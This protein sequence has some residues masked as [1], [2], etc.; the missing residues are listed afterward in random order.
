MNRNA[1][2]NYINGQR[3]YQ[4]SIAS[5]EEKK[6]TLNWW[7]GQ[8]S[9]S[10]AC[11]RNQQPRVYWSCASVVMNDATPLTPPSAWAELHF[12]MS[13]TYMYTPWRI[14]F[15]LQKNV[16]NKTMWTIY[17]RCTYK[18]VTKK[19]RIIVINTPY[20]KLS[21]MNMKVYFRSF[22]GYFNY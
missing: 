3:N 8:P 12:Q 17:V 10:I 6:Y 1:D 14:L 16:L 18:Y 11:T 5:V 19:F 20:I 13:T 9:G 22:E 2:E 7:K 4:I 21:K 15:K